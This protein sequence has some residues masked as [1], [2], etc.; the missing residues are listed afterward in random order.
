MKTWRDKKKEIRAKLGDERS[1]KIEAVAQIVNRLYE[2]RIELGWTQEYLAQKV[3]CRQEQIAR[4]ENGATMPRIDTV[5]EIAQALGLDLEF[6]GK[7]EAAAA[8]YG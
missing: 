3:G 1:N 8:A 5:V 4:I 2:R 7:E 6:K